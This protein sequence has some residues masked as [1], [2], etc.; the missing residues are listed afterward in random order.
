MTVSSPRSREQEDQ[1]PGLLPDGT[2]DPAYAAEL[3]LVRAPLGRRFLSILLDALVPLL[4]ASI[5]TSI[6]VLVVVNGD[7]DLPPAER[8]GFIPAMIAL[9]GTSIASFGFVLAQLILHGRRGTSLGKRITGIR[10]VNIA[11]LERPGVGRVLLRS[12]LVVAAGIV[13]LGSLVVVLSSIWDGT[14]R[15]RG[16]H[17][18]AGRLWLV[19]AR[20]GL[21]PYDE[22]AMRLARKRVAAGP[23]AQDEEVPSL[24][25]GASTSARFIEEGRSRSSV[26]GGAV[27][28]P[29]AA[30][31]SAAVP[32][33]PAEPMPADPRHVA[34]PPPRRVAAPS[35][36]VPSPSVPA[37]GIPAAAV[38]PAA[39]PTRAAQDS[40]RPASP[41]RPPAPTVA[42]RVGLV[43]DDGQAIEITG[44]ALLVGRNPAARAGESGV[45]LHP[46]A[47]PSFSMSKT[48]ALLGVDDEG[49]PWVEDRG[50]S[51]GTSVLRAVGG[52]QPCPPGQ[53]IDLAPGD[54]VQMGDRVFRVVAETPDPSR[55]PR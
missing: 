34:P 2:P 50:S 32:V 12:L 23:G 38:P 8:P 21:H 30:V 26:V 52:I 39:V 18:R 5:G 40:R 27:G 25:T 44:A 49:A 4:L 3:G 45:V 17:D 19:D 43:G 7:P 10:S 20:K 22:K 51:N 15:S 54:A 28:D 53:R 35:A 36:P 1:P 48:H 37:A 41:P 31:G 33:S 11:T 6:F 13:P 29:F 47:D 46:V 9:V 14:A 24:A 16:W 55:S 42:V